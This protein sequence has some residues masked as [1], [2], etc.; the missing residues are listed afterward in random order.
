MESRFAVWDTLDVRAF[1]FA[2]F[3]R[4]RAEDLAF[5]ILSGWFQT[6][7]DTIGFTDLRSE[8]ILRAELVS[9][10]QRHTWFEALAAAG[11]F[12]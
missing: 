4:D 9:A 1:L 11:S 10:T 12:I 8:N 6:S 3:V 5:T 7:L 2:L